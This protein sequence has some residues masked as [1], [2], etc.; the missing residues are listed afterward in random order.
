M[1]QKMKENLKKGFGKLLLFGMMTALFLGAGVKEAAAKDSDGNIVIVIDPGHGGNDPGK[2]GVNGVKEE[3][4]NY[5]IALAMK[6]ELEKYAGV[7]VYL[8]RPEDAWF[9]NTGRAMVA[10]ALNADYLISIH[11]NSGTETS[12]GAIVYT[13]VLPLYSTMTADMGNYILTNLAEL[14]IKNNGIQTRNSTEYVGE[15]YYTIMGEGMRAGVP[16][17]LIEHCFLSNP[18]DSLHVSHEDGTLDYEKV[19][20]IGQADAAAVIKYFNLQPNTASA[21]SNTAVELEKGY[22]VQVNPGKQGT[23]NISWISSNESVVKVDGSGFA[24]AVNSG[25]ANVMY[26]YEDGTNGYL[27]VTVKVPE[28]TALV[29]AIDPTFYSNAEEM[30]AIDLNS[31]FANVIYSDGSV[32]QVTPDRVGDVDLSRTGVQDVAITYGTLSGT[33]RIIYASSDYVPEV[34]SKEPETETETE[35]QPEPTAGETTAEPAQS[36]AGETREETADFDVM[37]LVKMAAGILIVILFGTV[38]YLLESRMNKKRRNR[39]RRRY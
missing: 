25:T 36:T 16:T 17:V 33:V 5:E 21:D 24:T 20:K 1:R 14:G 32:K 31:V 13:S 12:E 8:T 22:S 2:I 11:N 6:A 30:N 18:V 28:Q 19:A 3:D 29:G 34:T 10:A 26:S 4:A 37:M 15:D 35:K 7:R 39:R 27:A 38:I 23:G 9:T